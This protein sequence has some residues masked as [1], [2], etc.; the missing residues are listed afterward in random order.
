MRL[1]E[2]GAALVYDRWL[3]GDNRLTRQLIGRTGV[4]NRV[5]FGATIAAYPAFCLLSWAG[6]L[7]RR[8]LGLKPRVVWGPTP[9]LTISESSELLHRLGYPS[10]T[11]VFT[12]YHIRTD[13]DVNLQRAM[14]NPAV[15]YWL[16]NLL[17]LWSLLRFDVFHV[18]YDGGLWS[19]MNAV[20]RARWL[21]LPFLR[22]A[23]KRVI[24]SAYGSD[25]RVRQLN[26]H[27]QPYNICRECPEPGRYCVCGPHGLTRAKYHRDWCNAILAMGDMHEFVP[28]SRM[29]FNY[30]PIDVERVPYA[31][32]AARPGSVR[33]AHSP[34]H[35][36]FKG[37]RFVEDA[38]ATLREHGHDVELD[39]VE[40]VPNEEAK[41][42]YA[43]ADIVFA[44]CLAGWL[45]YTELEAMAAG[46]PVVGYIR[47]P[48]YL[49]HTNGSPLVSASPATLEAEL[50][51]LVADPERREELGRRGREYV[52]RWW[53]YEALAPQYDALHQEV[54]ERNG[55]RETLAARVD[56]LRR[57]ESRYR[58][59][60]PLHGPELGECPVVAD[61][62]VELDRI[63]R[64]DFG[65]PPL[66]EEGIPRFAQL[67]AYTEHPGLVARYALAAFHLGLHEPSAEH[68]ERFA[69]TARRLRDTL[70]VDEHGVGRWLHD[71]PVP[72][73]DL[74]QPRI[75]S[76]TQSLGLSVLL[77]AD[78]RLPGEGFGA[79][80]AAAAALFRTPADEGGLLLREYGL[81]WLEAE[82]GPEP[83]HPLTALT[84]GML[85]LSEYARVGEPWA[86]DVFAHLLATLRRRLSAYERRSGPRT[87]L[88]TE[89]P[90]SDDETYL[91]IQQLRALYGVTGLDELRRRADR[92]ARK[93]Y[94]LRTR[95]FVRG[96]AP[97]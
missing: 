44:Q 7:T 89:T 15:Y 68:D 59:G 92:W 29:D 10:T 56:E 47:D 26:E 32:A 55:L 46:K 28:G 79:A 65:Q 22:L 87:D 18:F 34:N 51:A 63:L 25:V 78:R 16:P 36:Y 41:R 67:G 72:G 1:L 54:W 53:S 96:L 9:I 62:R 69:V 38:V 2:R 64:G 30:W 14:R 76:A 27:W 83:A 11:V 13:F 23:G 84:T 74:P 21:E 91:A 50:E 93:L 42:R 73:R 60:R 45:G 3:E 71:F 20:P 85:A 4:V 39:L 12:T 33:I 81:T 43:E 77:R 37:T 80:A 17:H 75:S 97:L 58:V 6:T 90:M 52:E 86:D 35:R 19:G 88:A 40:G 31:G 8:A 24:A 5:A 95:R 57:G 94:L 49:A 82:P 48:R 61:P 66:D 70:V